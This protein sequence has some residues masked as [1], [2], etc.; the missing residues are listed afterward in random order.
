VTSAPAQATVTVT[1]P[2]GSRPSARPPIR[3]TQQGKLPPANSRQARRQAPC[4][5]VPGRVSVGAGELTV[6]RV[7]VRE[8]GRAVQGALV[9]ITGAGLVRRATT[10]AQGI[11][12]IRVR[13][14]RSGT[15]VIQSDRC[16]G[17]DRV[18]VLRA[19]RTSSQRPP[20][21]TG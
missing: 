2:A 14:R 13:P 4:V 8:R 10:N 21:V 1:S 9:R 18:R 20:R 6:V 3:V 17:A 12:V 7:R 5:A 16:S 11:A 19:R 15:L